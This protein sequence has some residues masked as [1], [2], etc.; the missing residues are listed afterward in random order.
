MPYHENACVVSSKI[1]FPNNAAKIKRQKMIGEM[2]D[3]DVL[4]SA[5]ISKNLLNSIRALIIIKEYISLV[6]GVF[7]LKNVNGASKGIAIRNV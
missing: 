3:K 2:S 5:A 4:V 7:Q 1:I 6:V